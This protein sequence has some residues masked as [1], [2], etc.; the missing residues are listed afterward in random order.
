MR[1]IRHR[2]LP[3]AIATALA[4]LAVTSGV[5]A[6]ASGPPAP[7]WPQSRYNAAQTGDNPA[8]TQL[9]V[10]NVGRLV[11]RAT[12]QLGMSF[13]AATP[14]VAGGPQNGPAELYAFGLPVPG[15]A[16]H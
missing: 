6:S 9:N 3:A 8:E 1:V 10:H 4:A 12:A 7:S 2:A 14:V 11:T 5:P 15:A 13:A 16:S